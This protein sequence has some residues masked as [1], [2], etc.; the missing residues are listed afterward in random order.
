MR[1]YP[2]GGAAL[3]VGSAK[4]AVKE[5]MQVAALPP[6]GMAGTQY[7]IAHCHEMAVRLSAPG[8]PSWALVGLCFSQRGEVGAVCSV[9][10]NECW[11]N[12]PKARA[13]VLVGAAPAYA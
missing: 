2:T 9:T 8:R 6:P 11:R 3:A 1:C 5:G 12:T 4:G 7:A 13:R 10:T